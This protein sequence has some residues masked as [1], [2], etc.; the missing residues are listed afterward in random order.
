M[1]LVREP[2][3]KS[4]I[5]KKNDIIKKGFELICEK[6]YHNVT[7]V[8]IAKYA[9]VSTGIIYQYFNDK[10]D[11]FLAGI[12]DYS[13][14][15]LYPM[16]NI[17][18]IKLDSKEDFKSLLVKMIDKFIQKHTISKKAHEELMAMS[19]LDEEVAKIFKDYEIEM[20]EKIA[21]ILEDNGFDIRNIEE[22]VHVVYGIMDN[23]CHEVVYHKHDKLNYEKMK[24]II[25]E[26]IVNV[27]FN[28]EI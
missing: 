28:K 20:T 10:R 25:I 15:I 3:K 1:G 11:I 16:L 24:D 22:K 5:K 21:K 7:C 19:C 13:A 6:G 27:L 23:Y 18:N 17:S 14:S 26:L 12:R 8:D 2:I 4:S 9:G